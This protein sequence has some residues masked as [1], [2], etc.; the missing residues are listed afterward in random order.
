MMKAYSYVMIMFILSL[1]VKSVI[2]LQCYNCVNVEVEEG[3]SSI[4]TGLIGRSNP[5]CGKDLRETTTCPS[6]TN[7]CASLNGYIRQKSVFGEIRAKIQVRG[8]IQDNG[9][10][11]GGCRKTNTIGNSIVGALLSAAV[12]S[13]VQVDAEMCTCKIY[14][15]LLCDGGIELGGYCY[16]Y[17]MVA[18]TS[19]GVL[20]LLIA[21]VSCCCCCCGC[22][23]C[24]CCKKGQR[25][26]VLSAQPY[27]TL[28][29]VHTA[30]QNAPGLS[31]QSGD[32]SGYE[33]PLG[34]M[35]GAVGG[36]PMDVEEYP[37]PYGPR[38]TTSSG[39]LP[40]ESSSTKAL[41]V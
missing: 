10:G 20:V 38:A 30:G 27:Q 18:L 34:P 19:V 13:E 25:G 16:K 22:C 6:N 39:G 12:A 40:W 1:A 41:V 31:I 29:F 5:R 17:W 2:G 7:A 26:V 23:G 24:C 14:M 35:G 9:D 11:I 28:T 8:C 15:C 37:P 33:N 32:I 21:L 3:T 4:I 36:A